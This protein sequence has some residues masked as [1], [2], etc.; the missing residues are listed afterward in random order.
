MYVHYVLINDSGRRCIPKKITL[1]TQSEHRQILAELRCPSR[2]LP[3]EN[4]IKQHHTQLYEKNK[5]ENVL[6]RFNDSST[7]MAIRASSY[8]VLRLSLLHIA[9]IT[10]NR[11]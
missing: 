7:V 9:S 3:P 2:Q 5:V 11:S 8:K 4:I 10:A 1:T 6:Y